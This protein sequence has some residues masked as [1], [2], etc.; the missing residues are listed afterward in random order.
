[1]LI[2]AVAGTGRKTRLGTHARQPGPGHFHLTREH[3]SLHAGHS[4]PHAV[5]S[6]RAD[7]LLGKRAEMY[8]ACAKSARNACELTNA[9]LRWAP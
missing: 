7:M 4:T 9:C 2:V 1:M 6:E 3:L 8:K 5:R